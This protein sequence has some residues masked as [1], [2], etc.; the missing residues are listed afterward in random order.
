MSCNE[1]PRTFEE[2]RRVMQRVQ[3]AVLMRDTHALLA[4]VAMLILLPVVACNA[5]SE[6]RAEARD[7]LQRLN[8]VDDQHSL[9]ERSAALDSLQRLRLVSADHVR[10]RDACHAA[11]LG[12]LR[13]ET[14]QAT[15]RQALAKGSEPGGALSAHEA[16]AITDDIA[17]S[18]K[19]LADAKARFP[20]CESATRDLL[21]K[22]H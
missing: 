3:K 17:A 21:N 10:T 7:L 14:L 13:A 15:A 12:L 8:A 1:S 11:H 5:Q 6:E 16:T 22:A 4:H 9:A 18:N 19:A 2:V 20:A